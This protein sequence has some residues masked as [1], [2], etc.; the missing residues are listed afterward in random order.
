MPLLELRGLR[1]AI[2]GVP[3]LRGVDLDLEPGKTL[4][5]V[6]ESGCGKSMTALAIMG[7][8]PGGATFAAASAVLDGRDLTSLRPRDWRNLRGGTVA[9][10]M[11]DPFTSL[12]PMMRVGDQ[13]AEVLVHQGGMAAREAWP[14]AVDMLGRVGVPTPSEAARRY[15]HQLSGGQRQRVVIAIAYAAKPKL[16]IA[17]EPTTALD[18]T[19]QAQILRLVQ[20]LQTSTGM[21]VLLVSHD[22]G[23]IGSVSDEVAVFYAGR[24]VERGSAEAV[25]HR[26]L[27]PYTR[28]LLAALPEAGAER[29]ASIPGQPPDF[30]ALAPGCSFAPRCPDRF[31]RCA[32]EPLSLV[33]DGRSCACWRAAG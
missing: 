23:V 18:V 11:Q 25:L 30:R 15:P 3:I 13:V 8:L 4:G 19:L 24:V 21:A 12:N 29:L 22:V 27:H 20:E 32:E 10:V 31:D 5:I 9:M 7:M 26:P 16:L 33:S 14:T 2:R 1:V 17:D 28:L 6:G